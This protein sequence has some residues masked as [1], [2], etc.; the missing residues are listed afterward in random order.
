LAFR[1]HTEVIML[2]RVVPCTL[3]ALCFAVSAP[4]AALERIE[5]FGFIEGDVVRD[6]YMFRGVRIA[7]DDRGGPFYDDAGSFDFLLDTPPGV[8]NF[9]P[10]TIDS[11]PGRVHASVGTYIFNVVDP[12]NPYVPSFTDRVEVA[13]SLVDK[14]PTVLTAYG[15]AGD[16]IETRTLELDT[17]QFAT[18]ILRIEL[19][20]QQIQRFTLTTPLESPSI[21]AVVDTIAFN[22]PAVLPWRD[23]D[24]DIRPG[25]QRNMIRLGGPGTV[26]VAILSSP[27]FDPTTL[28]PQK[29]LFQ[30]AH[31][32]SG[33]RL[34]R[35]HDRVPDL[36]LSFPV[37]SLEDLT[38]GSTTATLTAVDLDG[39]SLKGTDDV[40]VTVARPTPQPVAPL[41][42]E[43]EGTR[44]PRVLRE[45]R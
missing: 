25:S 31:V 36:I 42:T 34:D 19:P 13:V 27:G 16:V 2:R 30:H 41:T 17:F 40:M 28:D 3:L 1:H 23:I 44:Q 39:T 33:Q 45:S 29:I 21:G 7:P 20:I 11:G 4:A 26:S 22:T 43:Q 5:F 8:L 35:N 24:I 10:L 12:S 38:P 9:N 15:A 14:G 37:E 32:I 18:F 6:Q